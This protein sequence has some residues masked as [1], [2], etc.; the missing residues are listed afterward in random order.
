MNNIKALIFDFG[1]VLLDLDISKTE[2]AM[3]A[4]L[5]REI[6][7]PYPNDYKAM[8]YGLETGE[9]LP[10]QFIWQV[11]NMCHPIPEPLKVINAWNAMLCGWQKDRFALLDQLKK[12]YKVYLLSN[13]NQIHLD[14][15][16]QELKEVYEIDDFE[17]RF[18][19]QCFYS[20][21]MKA[22]KPEKNIYHQVESEIGLDPSEFVFIDDNQ[23]NVDGARELGWQAYLH[24]TNSDLSLSLKNAGVSL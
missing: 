7:F 1:G 8:T 15:V 23:N 5:N 20:H 21:R 9:I 13:T 22:W 4:L 19:D 2:R 6:K 16:F 17:N 14:Y 3:S 24:P 11:Q 10:E 18:F 12:N